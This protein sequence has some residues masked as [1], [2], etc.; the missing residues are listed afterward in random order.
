MYKR[1]YLFR[2]VFCC[3]WQLDLPLFPMLHEESR[4]LS[5]SCIFWFTALYI[6]AIDTTE[7]EIDAIKSKNTVDIHR[8]LYAWFAGATKDSSL[9]LYLLV[10]L[11]Q[12]KFFYVSK[13]KSKCYILNKK[14]FRHYFKQDF[15]QCLNIY[16]RFVQLST[17]LRQWYLKPTSLLMDVLVTTEFNLIPNM[18]T[19]WWW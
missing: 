1:Q 2:L 14:K 11:Y 3:F 6:F 18:M 8:F 16:L 13:W 10:C 17:V 12:I 5:F 19:M 9:N 4:N 7:T 15:T